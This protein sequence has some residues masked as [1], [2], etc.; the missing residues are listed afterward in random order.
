MTT[1]HDPSRPD[2]SDMYAVHQ[3]LRDSLGCASQLVRA[4]DRSDAARVGL[5]T[6]FYENVLLFLHV[7]HDGEEKLIFPLLRER[8]QGERA[9]V[10]Q[11]E[12]QHA[13]VV[14]LIERSHAALGAWAGGEPA[15]QEESAAALG[16]LDT[17]LEEHL[18]DEERQLLPLCADN[19]TLEE[20]GAL[21]GH[22]LGAFSG[23]KVWLILGLIRHQMTQDQRDAMLAHMPPPAVE[24]WTTMGE[25]AYKNLIAEVGPPI[26]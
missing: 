22:A 11:M 1:A 23:D 17:R 26:G 10:Q 21:P 4:V 16:D 8:C 13:D 15:A 7:H 19:V 25:Q 14:G 2:V 6:N 12:A 3:A 9:L 24:M 20:W 5:I 18:S